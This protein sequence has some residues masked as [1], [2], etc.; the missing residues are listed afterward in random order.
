MSGQ[1]QSRCKYRTKQVMRGVACS[2]RICV[3]TVQGMSFLAGRGEGF[4]V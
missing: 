3:G 2:G 4:V 1:G